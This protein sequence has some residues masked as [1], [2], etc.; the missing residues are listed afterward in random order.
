M[1]TGI[2]AVVVD[3]TP[4]IRMLL[5]MTLEMDGDITVVGEAGDGRAGVD[6]AVELQPDVVLIDLAMPVM[7]GL[8]ALPLIRAACPRTR[9]VVL[10]GFE[11]DAMAQRALDAGADGYLQKGL[12]VSDILDYVRLLTG[13]DANR[14]APAEP[15]AHPTATIRR[16]EFTVPPLDAADA[17]LV[18][19]TAGV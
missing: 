14:H 15:K 18:S 4:D 2:S 13:L 3:D 6:L 10:S 11:A 9:V 17:A 16:P 8:E 19:E 7:D 5:T 1:S 12:P